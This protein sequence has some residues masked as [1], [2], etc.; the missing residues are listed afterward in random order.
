VSARPAI[1]YARPVHELS[2]IVSLARLSAETHL[3]SFHAW[4]NNPRVSAFWELEGSREQHAEYVRRILENTAVEP[5]IGNFDGE[6]FAYFEAYWAER[7]RIAPYYDVRAFDRGIHM[8]VGEERYRGP[9]R[10]KAWMLGLVHYLLSSDPRT[11]RIVSEP[12]SDNAKMIGY[13]EQAGFAKVK[14]FDFPHKRAALMVLERGV[15][16]EK[17]AAA[18]RGEKSKPFVSR[19]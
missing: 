9:E 19:R 7:D 13:L 16:F 6:P 12:R 14:E 5:L 15:F 1:V 8:L 10:V 11:E 17:N 18:L 2:A 3:E 4:M